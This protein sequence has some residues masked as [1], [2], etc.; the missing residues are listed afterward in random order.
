M[1]EVRGGAW[2]Y[3]AAATQ[4][5]LKAATPLLRSGAV[6]RRSFPLPEARGSGWVELPHAQDQG[7]WPGRA[8]PRPR[9]SGYAGT[10]GPRG[11]TLHS[12]SGGVAMRR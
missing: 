8:T 3:Q 2:E 5:W 1:S 9:S 4:E 6:A 7:W 12:R 10:G 11:A